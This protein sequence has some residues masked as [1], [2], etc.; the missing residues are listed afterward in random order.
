VQSVF[1]ALYRRKDKADSRA[2][3]IDNKYIEKADWKRRTE[4][5]AENIKLLTRVFNLFIALIFKH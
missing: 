3:G 1:C 5:L 4:N 2:L